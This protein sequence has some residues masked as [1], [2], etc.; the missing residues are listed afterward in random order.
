MQA[1]SAYESAIRSLVPEC[2]LDVLLLGMGPDGHCCSLFP[3]HALLDEQQ[4]LVAPIFDSPKPPPQR[5]TMTFPLVN[6]A[7]SGCAHDTEQRGDL[8][9]R[10]APS[11]PWLTQACHRRSPGL[12]ESLS[13]LAPSHS[14]FS[15]ACAC[16]L[17][18]SPLSR[19]SLFVVTGGGKADALSTVM[20]QRRSNAAPA[21]AAFASFLPAARVR[22]QRVLFLADQD[23]AA[24]LDSKL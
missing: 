3:G 4:R 18:V 1:A 21:D 20:Q 13:I 12:A 7:R 8:Q 10:D 14:L 23:A 17:R 11:E 15:S 22:S 16:T 2:A 24:K 5:I 19:L 9:R 6:K